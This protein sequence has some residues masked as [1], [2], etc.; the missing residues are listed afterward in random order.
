M[1]INKSDIGFSKVYHQANEYT[2]ILHVNNTYLEPAMDDSPPTD[3]NTFATWLQSQDDVL[4]YIQGRTDNFGAITST[5]KHIYR[6]GSGL[7]TEVSVWN[8]G[9]ALYP[10]VLN[11]LRANR[12]GNNVQI[13]FGRDGGRSN[14][15]PFRN[16]HGR[17]PS[18]SNYSDTRVIHLLD[19]NRQRQII[20][21][22]AASEFSGVGSGFFTLNINNTVDI[23]NG[24]VI[25]SVL[26]NQ[27]N[28]D[29]PFFLVCADHE[30]QPWEEA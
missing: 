19:F 10:L 20:I 21:G 24:A 18:G 15:M 13:I 29:Q 1:S 14:D 25:V 17:P 4:S 5:Q 9:S 23:D 16:W 28:N 22:D 30:W 7:G 3:F 27:L 11:R 12:S 26:I 2:R 6:P 8:R